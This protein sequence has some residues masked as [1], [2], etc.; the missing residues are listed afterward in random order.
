MF[1][2]NIG[3]PFT[4]WILRI[5]L[6]LVLLY[7]GW[8]I[9]YRN[10]KFFNLYAIIAL[11]FYSLIQ[12]LRWNR[13]VDYHHYYSDLIGRWETPDP[14]PVYEFIVNIIS[15]VLYLPYWAGFIIY[16]ALLIGAFL[17]VLKLVPKAAVWALPLFFLITPS[18]ENII[19]QYLALA[20]VIYA[21]YAYLKGNK[22]LQYI[23][24]AIVP[25]IHVSGLFAVVMFIL[26]TNLKIRL[27]SPIG[28]VAGY[29][30]LYF[31]WNDSF[32]SLLTDSLSNLNVDGDH[33]MLGYTEDAG[34]WFSEEG[35]IGLVL[36]G[37]KTKIAMS[38][39][40]I[41]TIFL[42]NIVI[43]YYGFKLSKTQPQLQCAYYCAYFAILIKTVGGDIEMYARFYN[44][45]VW[46]SPL[47]IGAFMCFVPMKKLE[48]WIVAS[49]IF[50]Q[51]F[52]YGFIRQIGTIPFAG[53]AFV[54]DQ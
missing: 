50:A 42:S 14:E 25:L 16:S 44:W 31:F 33:R 21:F 43:I 2:T 49:I 7:C 10:E 17:L 35:S 3:D 26:F 11:V 18:S 30:L 38:R 32:F 5:I 4:Y 13:G 53:C 51:F 15:N 6:L 24:L 20:F 12:G 36:T 46:F 8:G 41:V 40:S 34:R 45:L 54:W 22:L 28:L 19:R 47:V 23:F 1:A 39:L 29:L 9:S 27:K 48:Y 37:E 52:F